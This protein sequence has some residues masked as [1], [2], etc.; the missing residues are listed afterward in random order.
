MEGRLTGFSLNRDGSQ[1]VTVTVTAD[2]AETY[3]ELKDEAVTVEI[4]KARKHRSLDANAYAWVLIDQIAERTH[5]KASEIYRNAI[6]EIGGVSDDLL[7]PMDAV[8]PFRQIWQKN[9]IGNQVELISA[10]QNTGW[11]QAR[12]YYGSSTY[13]TAQMSR[14]IDSLIQ[15]AEALGIPTITPQEEA[16]MLGK[17][18]EKKEGKAHGKRALD[19]SGTV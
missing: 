11:V 19:E 12:V 7:M 4:R 9:G 2:F 3:D 18:T 1:N 5:I 8:E 13:D 16:R 14:L 15:D 6:R 10:D 17:W